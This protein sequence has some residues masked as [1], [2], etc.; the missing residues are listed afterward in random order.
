[1]YEAPE[2]E[3]LLVRF[4][5]NLLQGTNVTNG[6]IPDID[7]DDVKDDTGLWGNN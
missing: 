1:M 5:G 3:L 7:D 2:T 4:E 6:G